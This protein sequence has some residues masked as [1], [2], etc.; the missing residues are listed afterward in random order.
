M[1]L[2]PKKDFIDAKCEKLYFDP[3]TNEPLKHPIARITLV[4]GEVM[5]S[6]WSPRLEQWLPK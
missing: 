4:N 3:N 1:K 2:I 6:R 5:F